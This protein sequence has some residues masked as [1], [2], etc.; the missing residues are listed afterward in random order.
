VIA[1]PTGVKKTLDV[2]SCEAC[3]E[4]HSALEFTEFR[5][6]RVRSIDGSPKLDS[7][8]DLLARCPL[9]KRLI[10]VDPANPLDGKSP[11]R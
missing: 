6:F 2:P 4:N 3:G 10:W 9:T 5:V 1:N 8:L 7:A 11:I